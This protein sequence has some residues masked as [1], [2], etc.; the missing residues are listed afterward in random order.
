MRVPICLIG[1]VVVGLLLCGCEE[2]VYF[3]NHEQELFSALAVRAVP[4][5][6]LTRAARIRA[7][8]VLAEGRARHGLTQEEIEQLVWDCGYWWIGIAECAAFGY[9]TG[10][11]IADGFMASP[12]HADAIRDGYFD[13]GVG[14]TGDDTCLAAVLLLGYR[15]NPLPPLPPWPRRGF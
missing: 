12:S 7:G 5:A 9:T 1:V 6:A 14:V 11:E 4:S 8:Q 15:G 2:L 3:T 10:Q 13:I